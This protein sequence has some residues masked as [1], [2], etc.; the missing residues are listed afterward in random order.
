MT[1]QKRIVEEREDCR[2]TLCLRG[3]LPVFFGLPLA[4]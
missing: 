3:H 2:A 1:A 4:R